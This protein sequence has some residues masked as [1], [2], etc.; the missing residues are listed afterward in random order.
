MILH[1]SL[2]DACRIL[3]PGTL[4]ISALVSFIYFVFYGVSSGISWP[5]FIALTP[6][7]TLALTLAAVSGVILVRHLTM[8][9]FRPV[10]KPLWS[11]YVWLNEMV[12]GAWESLA[13]P[14]MQPF[15]G[16]GLYSLLLRLM[17]CKIGKECWIETSLFSEFDL[18]HIGDRVC[19]NSG[20][21]VQNH[22][23]EDRIMKSSFVHIGNNCNVGQGSVILYDSR[24]EHGTEAGP[25]SLLM[26]GESIGGPAVW[27]GI[28]I[29]K[30]SQQDP[31]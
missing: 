25:L 13:V 15:M 20:V 28:P 18:V 5:V 17:G 14:A 2:V 24:M 23:F 16:T 22:L 3:I 11:P 9:R 8:G 26:K 21:I 29:A 7:V 31:P 4:Q 10:I 1:R 12:N 19:L 27:T 30:E 6:L